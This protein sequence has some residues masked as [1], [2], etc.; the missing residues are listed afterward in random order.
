MTKFQNASAQEI[1]KRLLAGGVALVP[2]DTVYGLAA[3]PSLPAAVARIF[4][5]KARPVTRNLPVMVSDIERVADLGV[6]LSKSAQRIFASPLVPGALTIAIGFGE[7]K[8]P[9]WLSG[10]EEVAIR[11]PNDDFLREVLRTTGPL[12]VTSANSHGATT[13]ERIDDILK[14]LHGSP[15]IVVDRGILSGT[16][17]T[18]INCRKDPA[19]IERAGSIPAERLNEILS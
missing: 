9:D 10:R 15:D 12:V 11:I 1:G 5:L 8:R 17:S 3:V 18:L 13:P 6:F 16:P 19:V 4:E 7:S 2:T 14:Q